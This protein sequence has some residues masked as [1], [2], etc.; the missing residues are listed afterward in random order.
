MKLSAAETKDAPRSDGRISIETADCFVRLGGDVRNEVPK[1]GITVPEIVLLRAI[2]GGSD[3][4]TKV[5]KKGSRNT[6]AVQE[7]ARLTALYG[8]R[9]DQRQVL[10]TLFP[11]F[12]PSFP[13]SVEEAEAMASAEFA[14]V[15][16][17]HDAA[18]SILE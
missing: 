10:E 17:M 15:E 16:T 4:V 7:K 6:T 18:E 8:R 1:I 3:T 12:R 13:L 5:V 14:D 9:E 2:H 11:G